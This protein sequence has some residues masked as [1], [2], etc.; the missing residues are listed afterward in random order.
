M[1]I[2]EANRICFMLRFKEKN[3]WCKKE[4]SLQMEVAALKK[5]VFCEHVKPDFYFFFHTYSLILERHS[6]NSCTRIC[7]PLPFPWTSPVLSVPLPAQLQSL[8]LSPV[9]L[10]LASSFKSYQLQKPLFFKNLAR[11]KGLKSRERKGESVQG[12]ENI[13]RGGKMRQFQNGV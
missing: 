1:L 12:S 3:V 9:L 10:K 13:F 7:C 2:R 6:L 5:T 4:K 11:E 8:Y